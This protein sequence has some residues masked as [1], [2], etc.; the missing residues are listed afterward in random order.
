MTDKDDGYIELLLKWGAGGQSPQVET[1][2]HAHGLSTLA[3]KQGL[4]VTGG[5]Q[6][7]ENVFSVSLENKQPPFE[8][9]IPA[10]LQPFVASI[11]L[12]RPRTYYH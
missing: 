5:R 10:E 12:P 1:W 6:Q 8:L 4:L 3:M 7:I 11:V 9:P 2:L